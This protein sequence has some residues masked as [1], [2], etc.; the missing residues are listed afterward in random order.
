MS[1][2][3]F[4]Q[5]HCCCFPVTK[6]YPT[7]SD[8]MN[9]ASLSFTISQSLLKLMFIELV[10]LSNPEVTFPLVRTQSPGHTYL[11][12]TGN[13]VFQLGNFVTQAE[14][15]LILEHCEMERKY[16]CVSALFGLSRQIL[17]QL[18][19]PDSKEDVEDIFLLHK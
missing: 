18:E 8:P 15:K 17:W 9:Q 2:L 1:T 13:L 6:S 3:Y 12:A 7:V 5:H 14:G 19:I 11:K 4:M 10:M 16:F